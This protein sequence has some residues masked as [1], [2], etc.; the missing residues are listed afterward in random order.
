MPLRLAVPVFRIVRV[1][2]AD[3]APMIREPRFK[4]ELAWTRPVPSARRISISGTATPSPV[5]GIWKG[6]SSASLLAT[7]RVAERRPAAV[8]R[9]ETVTLVEAPGAS[10]LAD[11][12]DAVKS[13]GMEPA[14]ESLEDLLAKMTPENQHGLALEGPAVGAE[15]W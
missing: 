5:S 12:V 10:V 3:P 14:R 2:D 4:V 1:W 11:R 13:C 6:F 9:N 8:G 7:T 15:V